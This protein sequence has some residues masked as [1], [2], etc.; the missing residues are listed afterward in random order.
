MVK[1]SKARIDPEEINSVHLPLSIL[2]IRIRVAYGYINS[3]LTVYNDVWCEY[4][5]A[6]MHEL[7]HNLDLG[8]SNE[9]EGDDG[10][11]EDQSCMMVRVLIPS[12]MHKCPS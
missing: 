6:Q 10:E 9:G 2:H 4:L 5:S 1:N 7:G 8:H 3:W 12:R 11:Y